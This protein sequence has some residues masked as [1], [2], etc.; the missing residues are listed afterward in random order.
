MRS[1]ELAAWAVVV[2]WTMLIIHLGAQSG[3]VSVSTSAAV[4]QKVT[5]A[6]TSAA[7]T[8]NIELTFESVHAFLRK[9]AHF[10][11]YASLGLLVYLALAKSWRVPRL[12][13]PFAFLAVVLI[14]TTDESVQ[15]FTPGRVGSMRD[16]FLDTAGGLLGL[17]LAA[18]AKKGISAPS[19]R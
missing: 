15:A 16:V 8:V 6:V 19:G 18:L 5:E 14:A 4:A 7:A 13:V 12:W 11:L 9:S 17:T 10:F 1:H 2:V 3:E